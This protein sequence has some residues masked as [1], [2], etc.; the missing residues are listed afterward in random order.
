MKSLTTTFVSLVAMA[1]SAQASLYTIPVTDIS[2]HETTLAPYS[3]KVVMIV[4]VA[5]KCG[6]TPQYE[7]LEALYQEHKDDGL[8]ILGFPCNQFGGQEPGTNADIVEFCTANY[9]VTF[10]LFD[11]VD[12]KGENQHPLYAALSGKDS[13]FPGDVG[14]NF[15]KFLVGRDGTIIARFDP[16]TKPESEEVTSAVEAALAAH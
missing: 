12:V 11:K 4:N 14:W 15:G 7:G 10:P 5:S 16:R 3:G 6:N 2:G 9:G 1:L 13:P 8:V